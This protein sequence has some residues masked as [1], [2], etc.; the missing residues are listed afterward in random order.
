MSEIQEIRKE[1]I[2]LIKKMHFAFLLQ[3]INFLCDQ[4][5]FLMQRCKIVFRW[6]DSFMKYLSLLLR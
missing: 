6:K 3:K 4:E 2:I 5:Y 1:N